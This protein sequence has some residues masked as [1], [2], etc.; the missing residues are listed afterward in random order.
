MLPIPE[1]SETPQKKT[2]RDFLFFWGG[3]KKCHRLRWKEVEDTDQLLEELRI[4][5]SAAQ[6]GQRLLNVLGGSWLVSPIYGP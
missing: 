3:E 2:P 6:W 4:S 1:R 5:Y